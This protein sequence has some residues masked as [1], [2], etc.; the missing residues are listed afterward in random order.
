MNSLQLPW[1]FDVYNYESDNHGDNCDKDDDIDDANDM[2]V[3]MMMIT[4]TNSESETL[5]AMIMMMITMTATILTVIIYEG[6]CLKTLWCS[7]DGEET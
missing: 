7:V 4:I 1:W 3:R 5:M 6:W 2:P